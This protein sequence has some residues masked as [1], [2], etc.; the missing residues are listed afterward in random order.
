VLGVWDW[1]FGTLYV[2]STERE[3]TTFGLAEQNHEATV[4]SM[5]LAP[6]AAMFVESDRPAGSYGQ[7]GNLRV[8]ASR[9]S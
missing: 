6:V 2:T 3:V 5:L 8:L 7:Q 9:S 4:T 1:L